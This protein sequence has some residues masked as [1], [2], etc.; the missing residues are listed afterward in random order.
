MKPKIEILIPVNTV[1]EANMRE[2]WQAKYRRKINQQTTVWAYLKVNENRRSLNL[3]LPAII[4]LTRIGVHDL[5]QDNLAGSNKHVQD[6]IAK[7]LGINDGDKRLMWEY[8]QRRPLPAEKSSLCDGK[9]GVQ[10]TIERP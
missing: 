6:T 3:K 10:I 8:E 7:F 5:D 2:C 9:Y 4:T 1:S